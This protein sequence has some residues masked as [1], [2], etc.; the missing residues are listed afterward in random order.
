MPMLLKIILSGSQNEN[1]DIHPSSAVF[2]LCNMDSVHT[3]QNKMPSLP[4]K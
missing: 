1:V 4:N 3:N 2:S